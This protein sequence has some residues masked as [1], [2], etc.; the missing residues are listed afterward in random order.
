[1]APLLGRKPYP[2]VKPPAEPPGPE[3]QHYTIEHTRETFRN[4]EYPLPP[5]YVSVC[6]SNSVCLLFLSLSPDNLS[7][8]SMAEENSCNRPFY[9]KVLDRFVLILFISCCPINDA[10]NWLTWEG[11][12]LEG[13][14]RSFGEMDF[15][16]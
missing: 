10:A 12:R 1:M 6:L 9:F 8:H 13:F 3:E 2:L 7:P 5:F 14:R 4:K 15:G 16:S 11:E